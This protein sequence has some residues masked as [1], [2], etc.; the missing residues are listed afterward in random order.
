MELESIFSLIGI[1]VS[2]IATG[3][4]AWMAVETRRMATVAA[5]ALEIERAPLLGFHDFR[6]EVSLGIGNQVD[7]TDPSQSNLVSI[8]VGIE[9]F[10]AGR[11]PV[12]YKMRSFRV[13][14]AS[15]TT[16]SEKYGSRGG[17]ILPGG[18]AIFWHPT[19]PLE[20]PVTTFPVTGR[21]RFAF[22]YFDDCSSK[23]Q[24]IIE[25]VEYTVGAAP[26]LPLNWI[27]IDETLAT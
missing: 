27:T 13:T 8:R 18:S 4:T 16:D 2:T 3:V 17:R 12:R 26:E 5:E 21:A 25:T 9:L 20:P 10:N 24:S 14:F 7:A 6:I 15:R 23:P 1:S 19:I 22:E 11:V